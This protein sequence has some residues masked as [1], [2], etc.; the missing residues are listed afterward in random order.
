M[1]DLGLEVHSNPGVHSDPAVTITN[2]AL[3]C[4]L[5]KSVS[6]VSHALVRETAALD[7]VTGEVALRQNEG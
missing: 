7:H 2:L 1:Y 6:D 3:K 5:G 4:F